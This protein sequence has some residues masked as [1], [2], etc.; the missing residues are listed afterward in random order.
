MQ[1][2]YFISVI[3]PNFNGMPYLKTAVNSIISQTHKDFELIIVDDGSKDNS[4]GY[5][6]GLKEKQIKLIKNKTNIGIAKSLNKAIRLSKGK[7]IARM[8]A[9]DIANPTRLKTQLQ[10]MLNNKDISLCGTWAEKINRKGQK[11]GV[12][13]YPTSDK[14]IKKVLPYYNP[15]IHPSWFIKKDVYKKLNGYKNDYNGAE[16]YEFLLRAR[17]HF[18]IANIPKILLKYRVSPQSQS[19]VMIKNIDKLDL[20]LKIKILRA[21]GFNLLLIIA[22]LKKVVVMKIPFNL[23]AKLTNFIDE[24]KK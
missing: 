10:F 2:K 24:F 7:Y 18:G 19:Q 9:D 12:I 13:E 22:I 8:D 15:V 17:N 21:E 16:D 6:N 5:L 3:L 1:T 20:K 14:I 4:L 11:I 23:R